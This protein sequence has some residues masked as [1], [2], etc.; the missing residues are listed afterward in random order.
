MASGAELRILFQGQ[1]D[2]KR[3][4]DETKRGLLDIQGAA[5]HLALSMAQGFITGQL[6]LDA[7]R[8]AIGLVKG[9]VL[10]FNSQLE[11][12]QIAFEVMIGSV[13]KARQH[14]EDLKKFA[15]VTPFAFG[16]LVQQSKRIQAYGIEI[17]NVIPTLTTLGNIA[18]GVGMDKLPNLT[19]AFGQTRAAGKLFGTEMRQF[20]EAGVPLIDALAQHFQ[21]ARGDIRKMTEDGK[22]GFKDVEA[23]LQSLAGEGGRFEN[24]MAR[25]A[26]TFQGA[27]ENIKDMM[28]QMSE[29]VTRDIF[30]SLRDGLVG[31]ADYLQTD[32]A[33]QWAIGFR[34]ALAALGEVA[35]AVFSS[36]GDAFGFF[37]NTLGVTGDDLSSFVSEFRSQMQTLRTTAVQ[38]VTLVRLGFTNLRSGLGSIILNIAQT[39]ASGFDAVKRKA[40]ELAE[41]LSMFVR[42]AAG[43]PIIGGFATGAA[44]VMDDLARG[45]RSSADGA[46]YY[47]EMLEEH[48]TNAQL[49]ANAVIT[50]G[51]Q[52]LIDL[53][54]AQ[55]KA[56]AGV[57]DADKATKALADGMSK[58]GGGGTA[59]L[60][61]F[62]VATA[63][64][65]QQGVLAQLA[66]DE[67]RKGIKALVA[68]GNLELAAEQYRLLGKDAK[69]AIQDILSDL[70]ELTREQERAAE[71]AQRLASEEARASAELA[72]E[73]ARHREEMMRANEEFMASQRAVLE[74]ARRLGVG[75]GAE[76]EAAVRANLKLEQDRQNEAKATEASERRRTEEYLDG[77]RSQHSEGIKAALEAMQRTAQFE[78]Q[79]LDAIERSNRA[80]QEAWARAQQE[81]QIREQLTAQLNLTAQR[82]GFGSERGLE[83]AGSQEVR[84]LFRDIKALLERDA[85]VLIDGVQAG[86][87][88]N[89]PGIR[90]G[91]VAAQ[92][93]GGYGF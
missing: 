49:E 44:D 42:G 45:L 52:R 26:R 72:N 25:Q 56:A 33:K 67:W 41:T 43:L 61:E 9:A 83:Q 22:I 14:M 82:F 6:A 13:D 30:A 75:I 58:G 77:L 80:R 93:G 86:R 50:E 39:V 17:E 18:A 51:T 59:A 70:K 12:S 55:A 92:M 34:E 89:A 78:G 84:A 38:A 11:Q 4:V 23:A 53:A 48:A 3:A 64:A 32:D 65:V 47:G 19:L 21:V 74:E 16:D 37:A 7:F 31:I 8:G 90:S 63:E 76:G 1:A 46:K 57:G 91:L 5:K 29:V 24:L 81:R 87:A 35:G 71:E 40:A 60:K 36:I 15:L 20:T 54:E 73:H 62:T 28:L 68:E 69:E 85:Q 88:V 66:Y 79:K 10:D 27:T 2:I